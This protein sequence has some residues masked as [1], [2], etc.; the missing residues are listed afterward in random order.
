MVNLSGPY[1]DELIDQIPFVV[2]PVH[3]GELIGLLYDVL[4]QPIRRR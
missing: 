1:I 2:K 3:F 4:G